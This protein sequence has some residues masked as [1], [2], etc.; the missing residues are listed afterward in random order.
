MGKRTNRKLSVKKE[1]MRKLNALSDEQLRA[2]AGGTLVVKDPSLFFTQACLNTN[3]CAGVRTGGGG[4]PTLLA[5]CDTRCNSV[6]C[7]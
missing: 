3:L 2:A 4:Y 7:P 6:D 1:T 5:S